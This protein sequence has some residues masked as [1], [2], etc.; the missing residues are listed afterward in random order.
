[1]KKPAAAAAKAKT[2]SASPTPM[3]IFAPW[4]RPLLPLAG[5]PAVDVDKVVGDAVDCVL[6]PS[7]VP[8]LADEELPVF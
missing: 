4:L 7:V 8:V 5:V 1:M 6:V 3:P 2:P